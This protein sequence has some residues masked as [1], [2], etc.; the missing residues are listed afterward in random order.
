MTQRTCVM[1]AGLLVE[2]ATTPDLFAQPRHPYTIGLLNSVV[3]HRSQEPAISVRSRAR[4]PTQTQPPRAAR[5]RPDAHGVCRSAGTHNPPLLTGADRSRPAVTTG[6]DVTPPG[7]LP[8]PGERRRG[9]CGPAAWRRVSWPPRTL[10]GRRER[11]MSAIVRRRP[12]DPHRGCTA[13]ALYTDRRGDRA[14]GRGTRPPRPFP[15]GGADRL[16]REPRHHPGSRRRQ[17]SRSSAARP[18]GLVGESGS[19]K[20][21]TGRAIVR[22]LDPTAVR[23]GSTDRRSRR[24]AASRCAGFASASR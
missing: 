13:C 6:P 14:A 22:L 17:T 10:R 3:A 19:G 8:Q 2:T 15:A 18:S 11:R 20:T 24:F 4:R 1:Y 5:S 12:R 9:R 23:S 16:A 21:T 7:R